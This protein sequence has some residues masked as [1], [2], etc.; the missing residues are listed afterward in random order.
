MGIFNNLLNKVL[1]TEIPFTKGN[2]IEIGIKLNNEEQQQEKEKFN[3][4]VN[5]T[6]EEITN[7]GFFKPEKISLLAEKINKIAVPGCGYQDPF[8]YDDCLSLDEKKSLGLNTRQKFSRDFIDC[9]SP[10]GLKHKNPKDILEVLWL[11]SYHAV[12]RRFDL[13]RMKKIGIKK[14]EISPCDDERDCSKIK[15]FK[16]IW[17]IDEVPELPLPGCTADYCRCSYFSKDIY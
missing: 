9:L 14:V 8:S 12:H 15:N 1:D 4:I 3:E 2:S 13:L 11:K 17:P 7:C 10:Q 16:K 5:R 6:I